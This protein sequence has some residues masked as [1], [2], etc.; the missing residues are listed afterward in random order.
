MEKRIE[1]K[2]VVTTFGK[3][4]FE[5]VSLGGSYEVRSWDNERRGYTVPTSGSLDV[6]QAK[7]AAL[8][9][10]MEELPSLMAE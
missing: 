8:V 10:M 7:M 6:C 2:Q 3:S 1:S 9:R 5:I 4:F